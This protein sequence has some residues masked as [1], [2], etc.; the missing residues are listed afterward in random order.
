VAI[1]PVRILAEALGI[2]AVFLLLH[3]H[4]HA[5]RVILLVLAGIIAAALKPIHHPQ[6]PSR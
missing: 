2:F 1:W 3:S 5:S 4:E 6:R